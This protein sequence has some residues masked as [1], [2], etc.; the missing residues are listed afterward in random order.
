MTTT[1]RNNLTG[2]QKEI[3]LS[4]TPRQVKYFGGNPYEEIVDMQNTYG[5]GVRIVKY[6]RRI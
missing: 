6:W 4:I 5:G 1:M 2:N 3:F